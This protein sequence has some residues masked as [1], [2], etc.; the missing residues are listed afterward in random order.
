MN[1]EY[2]GYDEVN[3]IK[4]LCRCKSTHFFLVPSYLQ[5]QVYVIIITHPFR[6]EIKVV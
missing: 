5:A 3:L 2:E 6:P 1:F 4:A